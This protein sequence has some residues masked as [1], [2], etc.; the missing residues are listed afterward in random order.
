MVLARCD[1]LEE[2]VR[3]LQAELAEVKQWQEDHDDA[4]T[5]AMQLSINDATA[6]ETSWQDVPGAS[7]SSSSSSSSTRSKVTL[8]A[9]QHQ[10]SRQ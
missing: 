5:E 2:Q 4:Q 3:K 1:K 6:D 9:N 8:L 7:L 10:A